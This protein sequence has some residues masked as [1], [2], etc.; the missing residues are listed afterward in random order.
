MFSFS[1][2]NAI[3]ALYE[4]VKGLTLGKKE[5]SVAARFIRLFESHGVHRN[6]IP[7]VFNHGLTVADFVNVENLHEK[8]SGDVLDDACKLFAVRREWLLG[9]SNQAYHLHSFDYRFEEI[10]EFI[11]KLEI[12]DGR[13]CP[14]LFVLKPKTDAGN[15]PF[16][17]V[18]QECIKFIGDEPSPLYRYHVCS[19][20]FYSSWKHRPYITVFIANCVFHRIY[21]KGWAVPDKLILA[22]SNG[23]I[24]PPL[25]ELKKISTL[26]NPDH[27][28]LEPEVFLDGIRHG[29]HDAL[30]LWLEFESKGFMKLGVGSKKEM[31]ARLRFEQELKKYL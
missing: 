30:K 29:K 7:D 2:L 14:I 21:V 31:E 24:I 4:R 12:F 28:A 27:M 11:D 26:W 10:K 22:A 9:A 25:K 6:Q 8:L 16:L 5:E 15:V 3:C 23:E 20:F 18:F 19:D 1:D 13:I 17:L